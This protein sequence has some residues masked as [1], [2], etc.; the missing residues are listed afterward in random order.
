MKQKT[1]R[2]GHGGE[3]I[4]P[5]ST[6]DTVE[7]SHNSSSKPYQCDLAIVGAGPA[8]LSF[9]C[10]LATSGLRICL[11]DKLAHEQLAEPAFDG[12]DIAMTHLSKT[13]LQE[14]NVWQRFSS[15]T[16]HPLKEATVQN[17]SSPY[18]LHFERTDDSEA[19]LGYLIANHAIRRALYE[20]A[21]EHDNIHFHLDS[22]VISVSSDDC[23]A[24]MTLDNERRVSAKLVVAADSR[25]SQTRRMMGIGAKMKDF[26]RVMIVCNMRHELSH[27]NRAQECFQYQRTCA[28]LPLSERQ[29]SIVITVPA[30]DASALIDLSPEAFAE[31]TAQ[32]L[33]H[34]LG[35]M[36]LTTERHSYPLVGAYADRFIGNRFALI[37]DA[38]VGMHP[39]TAHGY[40]LGLRSA[41]TLATQ[42]TKAH[43]A[44]RDIGS[45]KVLQQYQ[46]RHQLLA[47]PLYQSTNVIVRLF[48][49]N[50]TLARFARNAAIRVGNQVSPFK[51]MVTHRLTQI[52]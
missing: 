45:S 12:R 16:I 25:F 46:W 29:S 10:A 41:D 14:L 4:P 39:V 44:K 17:G 13:I 48:N 43:R 50:R 51:K 1:D 8:G 35:D 38:A 34:R 6:Q 47:R 19:P 7:P 40:N 20:E 2:D 49:D 32:F 42:I 28:I 26:G 15:S 21:I 37:G 5:N 23:S 9:A 27:H 52:R 30:G 36:T 18:A 31:Q 24:L 3:T 33:G 11:V 22:E